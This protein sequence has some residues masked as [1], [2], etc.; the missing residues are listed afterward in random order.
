M[1]SIAI[2]CGCFLLNPVSRADDDARRLSG[3]GRIPYM[4]FSKQYI[5]SESTQRDGKVG[6]KYSLVLVPNA[7]HIN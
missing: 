3:E 4:E 2:C 6:I 7:I 5:P 1:F